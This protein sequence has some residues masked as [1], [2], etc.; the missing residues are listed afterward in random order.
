MRVYRFGFEGGSLGLRDAPGVVA[1][2]DTRSEFRV[3]IFVATRPRTVRLCRIGT[4][5]DQEGTERIRDQGCTGGSC[6]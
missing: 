4:I 3:E 6:G 5:R 2:K 1:D